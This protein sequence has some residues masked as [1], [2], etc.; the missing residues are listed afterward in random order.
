MTAE[1]RPDDFTDILYKYTDQ[2]GAGKIPTTRTLRFARAAERNDPFDVY[3]ADLRGMDL[4]EF[5]AEA[6]DSF[7]DALPSDP[8]H[9]AA[10]SGGDRAKAPENADT[11]TWSLDGQ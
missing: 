3:I 4:E 2:N 7:F 1:S 11:S 8:N 9:F 6:R 5:F 10:A